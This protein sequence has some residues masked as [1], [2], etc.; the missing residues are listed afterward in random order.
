MAS[1]RKHLF[2]DEIN[3]QARYEQYL[4]LKKEFEDEEN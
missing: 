2:K 4:E 3:K 1:L